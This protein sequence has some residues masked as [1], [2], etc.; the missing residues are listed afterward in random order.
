[1]QIEFRQRNWRIRLEEGKSRILHNTLL[2]VDASLKC[3]K[4]EWQESLLLSLCSSPSAAPYFGDEKK[5]K[6]KECDI[7]KFDIDFW[8]PL[9]LNIL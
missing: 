5:K 2:P 7:E 1:M 6:K 4:A 9:C 3:F 8:F